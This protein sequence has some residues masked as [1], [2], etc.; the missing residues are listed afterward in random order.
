MARGQ[1]SE[2]E[3]RGVLEAWRRSGQPVERFA[4][5]RG[6]VPQRMRWWKMKLAAAEKGIAQKRL[7]RVL[8]RR[9]RDTPRRTRT[10]GCQ[11]A[12]RA[13]ARVRVSQSCL[14]FSKSRPAFAVARPR[15][16]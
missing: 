7:S 13:S 15:L 8:Q 5:Q 10:S 12:L 16:R 14:A 1:W 3:A 2:V 6:I 11:P 9:A 4:K